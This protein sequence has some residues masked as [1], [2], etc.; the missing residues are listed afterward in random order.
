MS[1]GRWPPGSDEGMARP[2]S[3]RVAVAVSGAGSNLRALVAAARRGDLGGEIVLVVADRD[4]PALAW[5]AEEGIATAVVPGGADAELAAALAGAS[6]DAVVLAGY[7]RIL[8]PATLVA[9]DGRILNTHPSLLPA[10]PGAHAVR[11]ALAAGVK[12]TGCTVHVATEHVDD[13]P[14]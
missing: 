10:F 5:A 12:V 11:D 3:G 6:A 7:M 4:C 1:R 13:G 2:V 8:G 9:F 14:I